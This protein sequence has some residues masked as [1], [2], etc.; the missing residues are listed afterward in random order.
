MDLG[1]AKK[2]KNFQDRTGDGKIDDFLNLL[3][4]RLNPVYAYRNIKGA[5]RQ[6]IDLGKIKASKNFEDR[7]GQDTSEL[8]W[9]YLLGKSALK[10]QG[11]D[12]DE[13]LKG[14]PSDEVNK[15]LFQKAL[16]EFGGGWMNTF[17]PTNRHPQGRGP[18]KRF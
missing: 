15:I 17:P 6:G 2:S 12:P 1:K 7:T 11:I 14:L 18:L 4:T 9:N 3:L 10:N 16:E 5:T 8:D 13:G